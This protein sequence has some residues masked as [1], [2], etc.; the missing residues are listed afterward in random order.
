MTGGGGGGGGG[1][2][3][4][5]LVQLAPERGTGFSYDPLTHAIEWMDAADFMI[6]PVRC[7]FYFWFPV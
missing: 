2:G 7:R 1:G 3:P 5:K 6:Q 4:I